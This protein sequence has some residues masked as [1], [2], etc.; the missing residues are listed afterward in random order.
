MPSSST[1]V[2]N[3]SASI[4]RYRWLGLTMPRSQRLTVL[5]VTPKPCCPCFMASVFSRSAISLWDN[6]TD[7]RNL[8]IAAFGTA[9]AALLVI[10]PRSSG[11]HEFGSLATAYGHAHTVG[12]PRPT[13]VALLE[14]PQI[15]P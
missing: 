12:H 10:V 13:I 5:A 15:R 2:P 8:E 6:P 9:S 14:I 1:V 4:R 7:P 11:R 3:S